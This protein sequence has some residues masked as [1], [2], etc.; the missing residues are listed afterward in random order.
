[1]KKLLYLCSEVNNQL[2]TNGYEKCKS[3]AERSVAQKDCS[4]V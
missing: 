1:M 3:K 2:K 4:S